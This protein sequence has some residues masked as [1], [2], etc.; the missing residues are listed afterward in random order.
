MPYRTAAAGISDR[1]PF[2]AVMGFLNDVPG[3]VVTHRSTK[4]VIAVHSV[5]F[6][7]TN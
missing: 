2:T 5:M 7:L 3:P 6:N 4:I 1:L